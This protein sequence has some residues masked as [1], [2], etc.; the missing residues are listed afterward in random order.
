MSKLINKIIGNCVVCPYVLYPDPDRDF[1]GDCWLCEH[2][3]APNDGIILES[4]EYMEVIE[5]PSW[6]PLPDFIEQ[7]QQKPIAFPLSQ[8]YSRRYKTILTMTW[9]II[10]LK[11]NFRQSNNIPDNLPDSEV[12][13]SPQMREAIALLE[14]LCQ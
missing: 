14:E 9:M 7:T 4:E 13:W 2:A 8:L 1:H 3:D 6:C 5:I 10:Q 12:G 11:W